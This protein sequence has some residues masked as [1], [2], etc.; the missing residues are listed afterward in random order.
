MVL[1]GRYAT[2]LIN[3][4]AKLDADDTQGDYWDASPCKLADL[5]QNRM[6]PILVKYASQNGFKVRFDMELFSFKEDPRTGIIES[7]LK[8]RLTDQDVKVRSKYLCGCDGANSTVVRDLQL[9]LHDEGPDG[10]ALNVWFD[11][12]LVSFL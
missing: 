12:D 9:P 6:E 8:D 7:V 1:F 2:R 10:L 4:D 11:A 3:D 5:P